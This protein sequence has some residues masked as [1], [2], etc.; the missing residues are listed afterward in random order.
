MPNTSE[1][2]IKSWVNKIKETANKV[3]EETVFIGHSIGCQ[4]ILRFLEKL[5]SEEKVGKCIFVAPWMNLDRKTIEEEGE[6]VKEIAKPWIETPIDF[7][8]VRSHCKN[9]VCLFST[10]DSYVS[11]SEEDIFKERL[12]AQ[13]VV[14]KNKGHFTGDDGVFE[15]PEILEFID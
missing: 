15:I 1:P 8:K 12:N 10:N 3:N 4:A 13:I 6:E 7:E 2:E 14:M 9:L 5:S 11:L